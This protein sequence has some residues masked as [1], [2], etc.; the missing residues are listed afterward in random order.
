MPEKSSG[1]TQSFKPA[2]FQYSN[3]KS[4]FKTYILSL[5]V[6]VLLTVLSYSR[7]VSRIS[8]RQT[9]SLEGGDHE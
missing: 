7:T 2:T 5:S 9:I 4:H 3:I 1:C 6:Y 8:D